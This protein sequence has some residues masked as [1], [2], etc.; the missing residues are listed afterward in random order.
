MILAYLRHTG[1]GDGR[2]PKTKLAKLLYLADFG[3]F[4]E[5][6]KSM[7]GM[8]YRKFQYGPVPD[9]YFRAIDE[10]QS[11][12]RIEIKQGED[13]ILISENRGSRARSLETLEK[14]E[15]LFIEEVAKR[16]KDKRTKEIVDF[17]HNQLPYKLCAD[18][19]IIP[20]ALITQEDPDHVY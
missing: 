20:Y 17:T 4:Y 7:S 5:N 1:A 13:L 9:A 14:R 3:W 8:S 6:L 11:E 10:L 19:E 2:I 16:W 18:D 12:G 15:L